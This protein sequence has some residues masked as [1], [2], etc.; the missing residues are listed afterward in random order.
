MS[1]DSSA[2]VTK[3]GQLND[4]KFKALITSTESTLARVSISVGE[5][6]NYGALKVSSTVTLNCDQNEVCIN[7][8]GELAFYKALELMQD[9]FS[10]YG[11]MVGPKEP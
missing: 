2:E 4:D 5:S 11:V 3:S 8:A 7:K 6:M 1:R 10:I 9:G